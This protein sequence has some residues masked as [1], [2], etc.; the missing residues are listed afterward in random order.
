MSPCF[1]DCAA[2][3]ACAVPRASD[4][5]T[6]ATVLAQA[7]YH[8]GSKLVAAGHNPMELKHGVEAAVRKRQR[9]VG[10]VDEARG[11][12]SGRRLMGAIALGPVVSAHA[13]DD[14]SIGI[15]QFPSSLHPYIDAETIKTKLEAAGAKAAIK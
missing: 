7:I 15:A 4:G 8:E 6:T 12:Q 5:T 9:L 2:R 11:S 1:R 14:L 10:A 3:A 13:K